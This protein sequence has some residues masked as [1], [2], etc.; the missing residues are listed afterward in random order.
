MSIAESSIGGGSALA[1]ADPLSPGGGAVG[2]AAAAGWPAAGG[3]GEGVPAVA[4]PG[5]FDGEGGV[6]ATGLVSGVWGLVC[7]AEL[8]AAARTAARAKRFMMSP[9][10]R[11]GRHHSAS[12]EVARVESVRLRNRSDSAR[13]DEAAPIADAKRCSAKRSSSKSASAFGSRVRPRDWI[14]GTM[15]TG[16]P[17][18][19]SAPS[20][21]SSSDAPCSRRACPTMARSNRRAIR[22]NRSGAPAALASTRRVSTSTSRPL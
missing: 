7:G 9:G 11:E 17:D 10:R 19:N 3:A 18:P 6:F 1:C 5:G 20:M 2:S 4:A 15:T 14:T 12:A 13:R 8:Q 16:R 22:P 21:S